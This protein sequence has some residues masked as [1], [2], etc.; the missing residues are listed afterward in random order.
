MSDT[1]KNVIN[2]YENIEITEEIENEIKSWLFKIK[3]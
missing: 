2:P 1:N 3:F